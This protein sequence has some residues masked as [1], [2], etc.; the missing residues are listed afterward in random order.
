MW[1]VV[2]LPIVDRELRVTARKPSTAWIRVAAALV[3]FL[4]GAGFLVFTQATGTS[5]VNLG[6]NLFGSLTWLALS[7][8]L[9]AGLFL[10]ADALS[11]EKREGTLG[12]LFLT[13]LGGFDVVSGKLLATSLRAGYSLL[14]IFPILA[15][16]LIMGGV[17]GGQFWR[18]ALALVNAL[19]CSLTA[20]LLASSVSRDSLRAMAGTFLV[21]LLVCALGPTLDAFLRGPTGFQP[22]LSL[23][24]PVYLFWAANAWGHAG[25]WPSLLASH[26]LAWG[27]LVGAA[28]LVP[29]TW[30]DRPVKPRRAGLAVPAGW[31][32]LATRKANRRRWLERNPIVWLT[33]PAKW[34]ANP[35][36][37]L[38]L[39]SLGIFVVLMI[40]ADP[41]FWVVWHQVGWVMTIGLYLWLS[42][43]AC[44]FLAEARRSGFLE[45]LLVTPVGCQA[46]VEGYWRALVCAF[47]LPVLIILLVQA[48][49]TVMAQKSTFLMMSGGAVTRLG[50]IWGLALALLAGLLAAASTLGNLAALVCV[51]MW[52]GLRDHKS[53]LAALKT[54]A[55]V[56]V[57]PWLA[58]SLVS[59]LL[60]VALMFGRM[61][62][63]G[64]PTVAMTLPLLMAGISAGLT[65]TKDVVFIL[66]ARKKLRRGFWL[67]ATRSSQVASIFIS[68]RAPISMPP[69]LPGKLGG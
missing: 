7:G 9:A 42:F 38:A 18:C 26:L 68:E 50:S 4:L 31:R 55:F 41:S 47:G 67:E 13:D 46:I 43:Q 21:L 16:T 6:H 51:G 44:R 29:R 24:S 58:I 34:Q 40:V 15:L 5:M 3:A 65:L 61:V 52:M 66:W 28:V 25:F 19:F 48:G 20:G 1:G 11:E 12:F 14:A 30:Q 39:A 59:T 45:L 57:L 64:S 53:S 56:M 33:L 22:R 35:V 17:T 63:A 49:A 10:T 27:M 23:S 62:G 36:W 2:F 54:L 32:K 60:A 37:V 69:V 8:T